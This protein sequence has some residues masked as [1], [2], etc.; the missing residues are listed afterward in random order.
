M[1]TVEPCNLLIIDEQVI[2]KVL[3]SRQ[4]VILQG[5][6]RDVYQYQIDIN[7][8]KLPDWAL[9]SMQDAYGTNDSF[10]KKRIKSPIFWI[11]R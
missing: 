5:E 7:V 1:K 4:N 11:M 3:W 6:C 10:G 9:W 8:N 2:G